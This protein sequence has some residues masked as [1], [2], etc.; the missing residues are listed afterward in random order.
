MAWDN[1]D[2]WR[3]TIDN[4]FSEWKVEEDIATT[5]LDAEELCA[6]IDSCLNA[7]EENYNA[8]TQSPSTPSSDDDKSSSNADFK[9]LASIGKW[10]RRDIAK[11]LA[12]ERN[13]RAKRMGKVQTLRNMLPGMST[14]KPTVNQILQKAIEVLEN[15]QS[16]SRP[17][18]QEQESFYR[19]LMRSSSMVASLV[20]D[21]NMCVV[22]ASQGLR[23][24]LHWPGDETSMRGEHLSAIIHPEDAFAINRLVEHHRMVPQPTAMRTSAVFSSFCSV[25][26]QANALAFPTG[27]LPRSPLA[28]SVCGAATT[29]LVESF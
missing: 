15:E 19:D 13:R 7:T 23:N 25:S 3:K 10:R 20:L 11:H 12:G 24:M 6:D 29:I 18:K 21:S 1:V 16:Q 8:Q 28:I 2:T 22:D 14:S 26:N 4:S 9:R 27:Y 5:V 17:R